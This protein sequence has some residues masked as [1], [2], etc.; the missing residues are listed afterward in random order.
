MACANRFTIGTAPIVARPA[1]MQSS[2]Y[3]HTGRHSR[4]TVQ[5]RGERMP[6]AIA[7]RS[8]PTASFLNRQ[9]AKNAKL[10]KAQGERK[11][12][13]ASAPP[14]IAENS[15]LKSASGGLGG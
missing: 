1:A 14:S 3:I 5:A 10:R 6:P 2:Q 4:L 15:I 12:T 9:D 13:D 7:A 8:N 11:S